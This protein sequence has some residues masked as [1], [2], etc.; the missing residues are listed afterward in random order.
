[1]FFIFLPLI[2]K[3]QYCSLYGN[4]NSFLLQGIVIEK[5]TFAVITLEPVW[6]ESEMKFKNK[7]QREDW[8]KLKYNVKKAY[9]YAIIA[10]ARLREYENVLKTIPS[11]KAR[12]LYMEK[13]EEKLK[14]EF[15]SD[16][17]KLTISQGRILIKLIDRETNKTSYELVKQLRG[18]FSAWMWQGLAKIFGSNLKSEYDP[19][20]EDRMIEVAINQIEN[21]R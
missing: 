5:D 20:N 7:R 19:K 4:E 18:S 9:P 11:E 1:M 21:G 10:S 16:L 12:K 6:V 14:K 15:E 3:P 8:Y 13:E 2:L 17:K